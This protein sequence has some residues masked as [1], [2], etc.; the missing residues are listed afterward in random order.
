MPPVI[1]PQNTWVVSDTHFGHKNIV[2]FCRRPEN[3]ESIMMEEWARAVPEDGVVLH[4]G[5]LCYKGNAFFKNMIAPHLTGSKKH[6]IM[7][8]HDRG[9][10]SFYRQCGFALIRKPFSL[11]YGRTG[12][13]YGV[14]PESER[15]KGDYR[16][17]FSHYPW[18]ESR[19][20]PMGENE[21]RL[22]GHIH[23]NGYTRDSYVPFL[24]GHINLSVEQTKYRP[25]NL[26]ELLDGYL[27]GAAGTQENPVGELEAGMEGVK[28]RAS[29]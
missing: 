28:P 10:F 9:R 17:S 20:G 8:N 18:N 24:K 27:Y 5:D 3:H 7:G 11:W 22:H 2:G 29:K 26:K 6:L 19:E 14:V 15:D 13:G 1:D 21:L 12:D 16:V 23:N 25:V 4:L